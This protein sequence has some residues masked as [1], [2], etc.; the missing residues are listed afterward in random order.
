MREALP[1][2]A[3]PPPPRRTTRHRVVTGRA[4]W[5]VVRPT[6]C[7]AICPWDR[8]RASSV[9]ASERRPGWAK[10]QSRVM[11]RTGGSTTLSVDGGTME[12]SS[13]GSQQ[14]RRGEVGKQ[15]YEMVQRLIG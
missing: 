10:R 6:H 4:H 13:E 7:P 12:A 15:T 1:R 3:R 8:S 14:P 2:F 5:Y 11:T 9:E